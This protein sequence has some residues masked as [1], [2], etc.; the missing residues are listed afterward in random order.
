L[1]KPVPIPGQLRFF[2]VNQVIIKKQTSI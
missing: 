1:N 2:E